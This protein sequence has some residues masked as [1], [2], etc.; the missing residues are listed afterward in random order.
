MEIQISLHALAMLV[1]HLP[2][3]SEELEKLAA[4]AAVDAI[5]QRHRDTSL[6]LARELRIEKEND[7]IK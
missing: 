1:K 3:A 7:S 2:P 5:E 6:K 4:A